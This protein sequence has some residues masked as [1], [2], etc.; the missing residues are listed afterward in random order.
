MAYKEL[1]PYDVTNEFLENYIEIGRCSVVT[2][3]THE[4]EYNNEQSERCCV[5]CGKNEVKKYR[6][7]E[8]WECELND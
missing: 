1:Y 3:G 5:Y 6:Q 7:E 2:Y 4:W 8:Y